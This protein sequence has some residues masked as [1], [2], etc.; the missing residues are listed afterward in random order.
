MHQACDRIVGG[1]PS[2]SATVAAFI[3][4]SVPAYGVLSEDDH[5]AGVAEQLSIHLAALAQRRSLS[6][7]ELAAASDFAARRA[8][9]GIPVDALI[10]AY[11]A[12][13][14]EIWRLIIDVGGHEVAPLMPE[15]GAL[16][17]AAT[18]ATTE[19]MAKAHSRVSRVIDSGRIAMAHQ[20]L[21]MLTEPRDH[22]DAMLLARQLGFAEDDPF[23][24][25]VWK[26]DGGMPAS[27]QLV[28][29]SL[30]APTDPLAVRAVE[31]GRF[32]IITQ[33]AE[34]ERVLAGIVGGAPVLGQLGI[35]V[36]RTGPAGASTS[37]QDARMAWAGTSPTTPTVHFADDWWQCVAL[38]EADRLRPV[39]DLAVAVAREQPQLAASV[40]AFAAADMSLAQ[41]ARRTHLHANTITYRLDRWAHLTGLSPRT[42]H[43]LACS[44]VACRL[45]ERDPGGRS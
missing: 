30:A 15:L 29:S 11:Q 25:V 27:A 24:G 4:G 44:I 21:E 6:T 23:V 28:A 19:V 9:Q 17:F 41:T 2:I 7:E 38:A 20:F 34:P 13:D 39:T 31:D 33:V 32:E 10:A 26:P 16:M 3:R 1:L 8:S 43:G 18:S 35:G 36:P 40:R 45:A 22:A 37:L 5:R 14:Q 42:F 12:G